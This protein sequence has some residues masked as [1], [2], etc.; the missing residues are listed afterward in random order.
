MI[1]MYKDMMKPITCTL[2]TFID[3]VNT[4]NGSKV[5][6]TGPKYTVDGAEKAYEGAPAQYEVGEKVEPNSP[7][8]Q[9]PEHFC[10]KVIGTTSMLMV[11]VRARTIVEHIL[12]WSS[13][14]NL[15]SDM[16]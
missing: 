6:S 11:I 3:S 8:Y 5:N 7:F 1:R 16:A 14:E 12:L 10:V 2:P 13:R 15:R 9:E 4:M